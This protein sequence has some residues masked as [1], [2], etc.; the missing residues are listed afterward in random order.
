MNKELNRFGMFL[1]GLTEDWVACLA[2]GCSAKL[3]AADAAYEG[4]PFKTEAEYNEHARDNH[5]WH[6][7]VA[8]E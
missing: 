6:T 3:C 2:G 4:G 5:V 1:V 8:K 7:L